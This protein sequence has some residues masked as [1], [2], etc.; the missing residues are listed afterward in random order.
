M[1]KDVDKFVAENRQRI[2][3]VDSRFTQVDSDQTRALSFGP[4]VIV[5]D[6]AI[7]VYKRPTGSQIIFGHAD[8]AHGFGRG[9]F[10]A[11][12][13]EWSLVTDTEASVE[14]TKLGRK[15]VSESLDGQTGA[16][17]EGTAGVDSTTASTSDTSLGDER[18]RVVAFALEDATN[19]VRV[20]SLF[21]ASTPTGVVE[22]GIEDGDGRLL[23]RVTISSPSIATDDEVRAD[24]IC[25]FE[26][27][28]IG[29]SVIT[30]AGEGVV[31]DA[32]RSP[33]VTTGP[34]EF[35]FGTGSTQ[36]GK[37]DTSL[38]SE[39]FRKDAVREVGRDTVNAI[40]H[41]YDEDPTTDPPIT[42]SHSFDLSE[43]AIFDDAGTMIWATTYRSLAKTESNGFNAESLILIA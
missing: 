22:F 6:V 37:S 19:A 34:T 33:K 27:D 8:D 10:G 32:F 17:E 14:F 36:F 43:M 28:G 21:G 16:V 26:G 20:R 11:D 25:T 1:S 35:A 3:G 38:T 13:G 18:E 41:V 12:K 40:T 31:A 24:M 4:N 7:E 5:V 29:N 39:V 9:T 2:R 30:E 23:A 42:G 15:A